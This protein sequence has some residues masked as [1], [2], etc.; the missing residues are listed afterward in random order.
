MDDNFID[1]YEELS[2]WDIKSIFNYIKNHF[3]QLILLCFVFIIVYVIEH[4]TYINAMIFSMPSP[5]QPQINISK[6]K[7]KK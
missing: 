6:N 7:R 1:Y 2:F 3:I 5:I 4:V